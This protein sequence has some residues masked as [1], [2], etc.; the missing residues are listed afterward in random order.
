[1]DRVEQMTVKTMTKSF[2]N[3]KPQILFFKPFL[4]IKYTKL[5]INSFIMF[6]Y[7]QTKMHSDTFNV[8]HIITVNKLKTECF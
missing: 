8:F 7:S 5:N 6:I 1:M 4:I 2:L 3:D